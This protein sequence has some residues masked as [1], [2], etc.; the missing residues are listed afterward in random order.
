M[1]VLETLI[2]FFFLSDI[3]THGQLVTNTKAGHIFILSRP[4][5]VI[6]S[7]IVYILYKIKIYMNIYVIYKYTLH[8]YCSQYYFP[9][10]NY[11][12]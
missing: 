9:Y 1:F 4:P 10:P 3:H 6:Y 11:L 8:F 7:K 2:F 12:T 5:L